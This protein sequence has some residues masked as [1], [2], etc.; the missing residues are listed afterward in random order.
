MLRRLVVAVLILV[1]G[2]VQAWRPITGGAGATS[3]ALIVAA[4]VVAAAAALIPRAVSVVAGGL[5][6]IV[7]LVSAKVASASPSPELLIPGPAILL[8]TGW[9]LERR[10]G[11]TG[12]T[13]RP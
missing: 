1:V 3:T 9:L 10:A 12:A 5:L 6:S 4:M 13:A 8:F 11:G 2:A 7:F